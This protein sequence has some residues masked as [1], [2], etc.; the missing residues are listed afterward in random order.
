MRHR[1][2]AIC[3][4]FAMFPESFADTWIERLTKRG[5][6][7]LDLFSGRGTTATCALLAGRKAVASDVNDV[8]YCLTKAKTNAPTRASALKR[9]ASLRS[10]YSEASVNREAAK[11]PE[12]FHYA[13]HPAT[14]RQ[15]LYLR[16][17]LDWRRRKTDTMIAALALGA[18]HGE[19]DKSSAYFS[20]QMPR[21]ISTKPAYSVRFWKTRK[22]VAPPRNAFDLLEKAVEYRYESD[23]PKGESVILNR[24][25]RQLVLAKEMFPGPVRCVITSPPYFDV[26]NFE[27]DQWLRLWFLGGPPHPTT[28]R[29]SRDDRH[30]F[31]SNYWRFIADMWRCLGVVLGRSSH[32]VVRLGSSRLSTEELQRQLVATSVFSGRKVELIETECS[33]IKR[34]QTDAFRPG[35]VGCKVEIDCHF[36]VTGKIALCQRLSALS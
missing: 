22:L 21:S 3:P 36:H 19:A 4:Y 14:L 31:A 32:V 29:L 35:T 20:N 28:G 10:E 26:T 23:P 27:E 18:L 6:V 15:V 1:F 16:I 12:F 13:F 34:R 11:L 30:T 9:V 24:D 25:M 7:V 17:A 5:D 2:H 33:K 8:A